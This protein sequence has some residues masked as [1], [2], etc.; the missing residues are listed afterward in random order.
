MKI[1]DGKHRASMLGMAKFIAAVAITYFHALNGTHGN[2]SLLYLLVEFFFFVTGYYTYKHF[3]TVIGNDS[4]RATV[5]TKVKRALKYTVSKIKGLLPYIIIAIVLRYIAVLYSVRIGQTSLVDALCNLPFEI[6][7]LGSQTGWFSWPLWFISAMVI[8]MPLFCFIAQSRSKWLT[9][10]MC[11]LSCIVYYFSVVNVVGLSASGFSAL[12]RA[13]AGM[14][15]GVVIYVFAGQ[16]NKLRLS[17][18]KK[19]IIQTVEILSFCMAFVFMYPSDMTSNL[20]IYRNLVYMSFFVFL[21]VFM[22][23]QTITS[24]L[25]CKT[26][27]FLEK[28]SMVLFMVHFPIMSLI[29]FLP[30]ALAY[31][32]R[33]VLIIGVSVFASI[34]TYCAVDYVKVLRRIES[35]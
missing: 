13:F 8:V 14:M 11:L 4:E 20:S 33:M 12:L 22:S 17:K 18:F 26:M 28:I 35:C 10:M 6:T 19:A 34:I 29:D 1:V 5:E 16:V 21:V 24:K 2:W 3:Q 15:T 31:Q 23:G 7:L 25:S 9:F 32:T 30:I 27:D